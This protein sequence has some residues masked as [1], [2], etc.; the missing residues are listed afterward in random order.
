MPTLTVHTLEEIEQFR[1]HVFIAAW[2]TTSSLARMLNE[3]GGIEVIHEL[4]F[5]NIA[6]NPFRSEEAYNFTEAINQSF[7]ALVSFAGADFILRSHSNTPPLQ[8]N[9]GPTSGYDIQNADGSIVAECFAAVSPDNNK[10]FMTDFTRLQE[11]NADHKYLF[12]YSPTAD[13]RDP[14]KDDIIRVVQFTRH[15]I[16]QQSPGELRA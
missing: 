11:A 5:S 3:R 4:R 8:L 1:Q 12:F 16:G 14:P 13:Y 15:Q 9:I 7:T 6:F 2:N 10:K